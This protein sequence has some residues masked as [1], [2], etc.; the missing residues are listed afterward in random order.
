M[1]V[2][3]ATVGNIGCQACQAIGCIAGA[4]CE[5]TFRTRRLH[6]GGQTLTPIPIP[7]SS[8]RDLPLSAVPK[9]FDLG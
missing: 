8:L 9:A 7:S 1:D 6:V 2:R 3:C 5:T 4:A